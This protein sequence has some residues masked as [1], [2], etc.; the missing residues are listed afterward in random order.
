MRT[1]CGVVGVRRVI[2]DSVLG[3]ALVAAVVYGV[4]LAQADPPSDAGAPP[5]FVDYP[6]IVGKPMPGG[7]V[8]LSVPVAVGAAPVTTACQWQ[9]GGTGSTGAGWADISGATAC[10]G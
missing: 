2:R 5:Q 7:T 6:S 10:S 9:D 8:S 3:L 4:G 1:L